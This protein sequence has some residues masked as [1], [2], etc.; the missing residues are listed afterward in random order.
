VRENGPTGIITLLLLA[1]VDV[2]P[3]GIIADYMQSPDPERDEILERELP[4][5]EA[6]YPVHWQDWTWRATS[7][8]AGY[9]RMT[10]LPFACG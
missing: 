7:A 5:F 10:W 2:L 9:V 4:P 3:E 1:L 8:W 6:P